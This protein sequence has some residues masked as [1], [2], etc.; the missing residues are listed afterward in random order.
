[1]PNTLQQGLLV[2]NTA[3]EGV[4]RGPEGYDPDIIHLSSRGP[5]DRENCSVNPESIEFKAVEIDAAKALHFFFVCA[6]HVKYAEKTKYDKNWFSP[7]DIDIPSGDEIR[8]DAYALSGEVYLKYFQALSESPEKAE[9]IRMDWYQQSENAKQSIQDK[10]NRLLNANDNKVR[11]AGS[12]IK[13]LAGVE[14]V[15]TVTIKLVKSFAGKSGMIVDIV[16]EST[17]SG[18]DSYA[19]TNSNLDFHKAAIVK[20]G[21]ESYK[22]VQETLNEKAV[23]IALSKPISSTAENFRNQ[24]KV[25]DGLEKKI[26]KTIRTA[27]SDKATNASKSKASKEVSRLIEKRALEKSVLKKA[28][29]KKL[30][31]TAATKGLGNILNVYYIKKDIVE[32]WDKLNKRYA[33]Q[34]NSSL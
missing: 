17:V 30:A 8:E 1:M 2:G 10:F 20:V 19:K 34:R 15:S 9:N 26:H 4:A 33:D 12:A 11:T 29:G 3:G 32:A 28:A 24:K 21:E 6:F 23:R 25:V 31:T 5:L 16:Y 14:F 27:I 18:F 22:E 13:F 7:D